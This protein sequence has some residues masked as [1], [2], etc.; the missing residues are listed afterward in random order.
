M[1][2][3]SADSE[4]IN[5]ALE[6]HSRA[7]DDWR[8]HEVNTVL[9]EWAERFNIEF[10]ME[11]P[12]SVMRLGPLC[13]GAWLLPTWQKRFWASPRNYA[14]YQ[15]TAAAAGY[16][17]EPTLIADNRLASSSASWHEE[18]FGVEVRALQDKSI[19]RSLLGLDEKELARL[20]MDRGAAQGFTDQD[21]ERC[22]A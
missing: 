4:P 5:A 9:Q 21:A 14:E 7:V 3:R 12:T 11:L 13:A 6:E 8:F 17:S 20:L 10:N 2:D 19:G 1:G 18:I 22:G 15:I 16:V